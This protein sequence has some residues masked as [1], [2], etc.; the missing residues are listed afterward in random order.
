MALGL[1]TL[2]RSLNTVATGL[3]ASVNS[4]KDWNIFLSSRGR[5]FLLAPGPHPRRELSPTPRLGFPC[6]RLGV[7]AGARSPVRG[8]T[9]TAA[10]VAMPQPRLATAPGRRWFRG[11]VAPPPA[12][13]SFKRK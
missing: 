4:F 6:P 3:T 12:R 11:H 8:G 5:Y 9:A 1:V 13:D 10:A 2:T 7:A